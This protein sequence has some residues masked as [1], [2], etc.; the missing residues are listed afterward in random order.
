MQEL[1]TT[2]EKKEIIWQAPEFKEYAKHPLWFVGFSLTVAL[3]VLFGIFTKSW[4]T[5]VVFLL[6]GI[7]GVVYASQR[8]RTITVK[9]N[10][11]GVQVDNL[12]YSFK[13]IKKFWIVYYPPEV[14]VLY[15]ET[16]AY[17][18]RIMKLELLNQDPIELRDFLKT[19]VEEDLEGEENLVDVISRKIK[20]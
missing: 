12:M 15:L 20:F 5:S 18:N 7:L 10:G 19:Y 1:K 17:L 4:T 3:L 11:L 14:K 6:M 8:P 2:S 16:S 9:V 13:T